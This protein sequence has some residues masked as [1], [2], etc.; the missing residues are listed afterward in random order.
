MFGS[1]PGSGLAGDLDPEP[2]DP[3]GH[4]SHRNAQVVV[5]QHGDLGS[6]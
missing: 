3:C 2:L 6:I 1:V 4:L 5:G